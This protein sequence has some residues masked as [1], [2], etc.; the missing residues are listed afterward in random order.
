VTCFR[1]LTPYTFSG[2]AHTAPYGSA[3]AAPPALNVGWLDADHGVRTEDPPPGL[4]QALAQLARDPVNVT[5]GMHLCELCDEPVRGAPLQ[6][7]GETVYLG[8]GEIRVTGEDGTVFAA[9]TL[10]A[11]YVAEHDYLPPQEFVDAV[12][13]R[14]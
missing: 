12:L 9:P 7:D 11:H 13:R 5:R 4:V 10:I 6:V 8:N 3:A 1:D 2:G 14:S